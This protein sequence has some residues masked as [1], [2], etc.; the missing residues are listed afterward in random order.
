MP[1]P[2]SRPQVSLLLLVLF[3]LGC[4]YLGVLFSRLATALPNATTMDEIGE[5]ALG[6]WGKRSV[7]LVFYTSVVSCCGWADGHVCAAPRALACMG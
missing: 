6:K 2:V 1:P 3:S 7:F 5:G 4:G